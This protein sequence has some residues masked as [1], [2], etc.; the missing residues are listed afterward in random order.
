MLSVAFVRIIGGQTISGVPMIQYAADPF[1]PPSAYDPDVDVTYVAG[2]GNAWLFDYLGT[3]L[4]RVLLRHNYAGFTD[5]LGYGET[6]MVGSQPVNLTTAG[7]AVIQ[8]YQV[9]RG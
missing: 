6:Y 1:T 9:I 8:A 3:P 7:G 5:P 4:V 2:I